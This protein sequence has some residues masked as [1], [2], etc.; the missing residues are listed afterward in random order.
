MTRMRFSFPQK[1]G[2][3]IAASVVIVATFLLAG[4]GAAYWQ[5]GRSVELA[6][7]KPSIVHDLKE[8]A[9]AAE[10]QTDCYRA[11]ATTAYETVDT[12]AILAA[13]SGEEVDQSLLFGCHTFLHFYGQEAGRAAEHIGEALA[14]GSPVCFAGYYHGVLENYF[15][16]HALNPAAAPR[17]VTEAVPMLCVRSYFDLEQN[18]YQCLHGLGHSLMFATDGELPQAL[19]HCDALAGAVEQEWCY[20]GAFMENA[21]SNTNPVHP[22]KYVRADDPAYP[23]TILQERYLSSCYQQQ[24]GYLIGYYQADWEKILDF[25]STIPGAYQ[26]RCFNGIGQQLVGSMDMPQVVERCVYAQ[27]A[28]TE[29]QCLWG[30]IV[31]V[32]EAYPQSPERTLVFCTLVPEGFQRECVERATGTL[33]ARTPTLE[34]ARTLCTA[35]EDESLRRTCTEA[36]TP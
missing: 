8:C 35:L 5:H 22:S 25:C 3:R 14:V 27:K 33:A 34:R 4:A 28:D 15:L 24:S 31:A 12:A 6:A 26:S 10:G 11:L 9:R 16:E 13:L 2:R 21:F 32:G 20:S 1:F 29:H 7:T 30:A 36:L 19:G 17:A 23:C 18:Y